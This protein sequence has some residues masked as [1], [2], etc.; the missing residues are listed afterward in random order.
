[1]KKNHSAGYTLTTKQRV[2]FEKVWK[3]MVMSIAVKTLELPIVKLTTILSTPKGSNSASF[4][5]ASLE[6]KER[7]I[8]EEQFLMR[9]KFLIPVK[10]K[11]N[12]HP[13]AVKVN[14]LIQYVQD[15]A[16]TDIFPSRNF[17][18]NTSR[19]YGEKCLKTALLRIFDD[20]RFAVAAGKKK[21]WYEIDLDRLEEFQSNS[22]PENV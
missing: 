14:R 10:G 1:M 19:A 17:A 2:Q 12:L 4:Q 9:A 6:L 16:D 20:K 18:F 22:T 3:M 8:T 7:L 13:G 5:P 11:K 21:Q 15:K